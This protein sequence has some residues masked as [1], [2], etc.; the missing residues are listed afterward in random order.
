MPDR[1]QMKSVLAALVFLTAVIN[2]L[3]AEPARKFLPGQVISVTSRLTPIAQLAATNELHLAIS[4]PLRNERELDELLHQ[5]YDP[6]SLNF[7]KFL[8]SPEFAA[9]F[10]PTESDYAA[11]IGFVENR[12]LKVTHTHPNR[13]VLD[14]AGDVAHI[15]DSFQVTLNRYAHPN[16]PREFFSPTGEPSVP[17]G[18]NVSGISGLNNFSLP[19]PNSKI[20]PLSAAGKRVVPNA[21][22]GP[23]SGYMGGDFRAAYVP[24]VSL[25]GAS[26]SVAL[27]QFDGYVSNDIAA[28]ISWA[29]LGS[30]PISLTNVPVNGGVSVPGAGNGEVCLDIEM[31]LAMAPGV[32]KIIVYEAPNGSTSWSTILSQIANDNLARQVSC[33][34]GG[35]STDSGVN[36]IFKQMAAQG[37]SFFCASGD[38]D[39][40]TTS[41]PFLLDNTNIT[42][43]GGT[44]LTTASAG[45]AY[46]SETVWNDRTV[47]PNGGNWGSSGGVSPTYKIPS[48][49][50]SIDMTSNLGSTTMRNLPDVALTGDNCFIVADTNQLE[51]AGGTS[52]AAPLWAGFMALV[53]EQAA[54]AGRSPV[55]FLNPSIYAIGNGTNYASSLH[56]ITSGDNYWSSSPAKYPAV[57]GYDLCTGW[58]TPSGQP[59]MDALV[60]VAE[61]LGVL[62]DTGFTTVRGQIGGPFASAPQSVSLT[63]FSAVPLGWSVISTSAWLT[64]SASS[65]NLLA[66]GQTNL[67]VSVSAAANALPGGTYSAAVIFSNQTSGLAQSRLFMLKVFEPLQLL[68]TNGL[69][70]CGAAGGPFYPNT[71]LVTFTN[72]GSGAVAWSLINTSAWLSVSSV[73]G[74]FAG[75][76]LASVT[77][78]TNAVTAGL[79]NGTYNASLVL[80][81]QASHSAQSLFF[82]ALIGT[83]MV[84]NG[85]FETGDLTAWTLSGN[86]NSISSSISVRNTSTYIHSGSYGLRAQVSSPMGYLAQNLPTVPGQTYQLSFWFISSSASS[87][88]QFQATWNGTNVY[89]TS[90]PPT[91]WTN[92]KFIVTATSTN[93]QLQFGFLTGSTPRFGFDDISV[94]PVNLPVITQQPI[95]Q[96]N[97][98]G[99]NVSFIA[100]ATGSA[101]L[102][103]QWRTNGV[104]L[105]GANTNT[106]NLTAV[107]A[108]NSGNYA[109]VVTNAYGA[110]TS[111]VVT[112]AVVLPPA[113]TGS[114]LTNRTAEC[115]KNTN[116]YT[117]I[118]TGTAPLG[119][120][121]SLNGTPFAGAT[122]TSF[123]LTNLFVS[124]NLI[125]VIITNLY[126]SAG[127]NAVLM[128]QDTLTPVISWN[129]TNLMVAANSNC[130]ALLTN[131]TGTN[132]ILATDLSGSVTITQSPTNNATLQLGTNPVVLTVADA[133]GNKSYAT[134]TVVVQDQTPPQILSQPQSLTN[135]IGTT[136]T[137][138]FAAIA[139]TPLAFQWYSNNTAVAFFTNATLTLSNLV[140]SAAGNYF[141]VASANGG[142]TT[143][144]VVTLTVNL[145]PPAIHAVA[146]NSNNGFN[147]NLSGTPGYTY[148]L[149][150]TTNLLPPAN[151]LPLAT[152]TPGTN[153]VWSFTDPS[154]TN[155]PFQFYRL[156]LA[157]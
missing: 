28:Y 49:Q 53:N 116:T 56:D 24:G 33:S 106:L 127:S 44:V 122:N 107:T 34:W 57:A 26:Q 52:C 147:L 1:A 59:L 118:A 25:T 17:A 61:P 7:H 140:L 21:G 95:S 135:F 73:V 154:A 11:V 146:L 151:W 35:G 157:P 131:M 39:A 76:S 66:G 38:Y 105:T 109:L 14:V 156:K 121:W 148:I 64:V 46:V 99:S 111:S 80:S 139:C 91:S 20:S 60:G 36:A 96:T 72:Q 125:S 129:F 68:A 138:N 55:G 12:G 86:T 81:N 92:Q 144:G 143:S 71:A 40:Y 41:V 93:T 84:S 114:S 141:A 136:A 31:V 123:S 155:F 150:A 30:Y 137:F 82:S 134:N 113:I 89:S 98:A 104:N 79:A 90:S 37:Q 18:L 77:V 63:N 133:S 43:V 142:A 126:G 97:L 88:Q 42:L 152:G 6:R 27:L 2:G 8:T 51:I 108:N 87:G 119:I 128:V 120:Q 3:G 62:P 110:I 112:L 32:S 47:N 100:S 145:Y 15:E 69:T 101:P 103:F 124:T 45:G 74:S 10:G 13:L 75:N 65:G 78:F 67:T 5:L 115:G 94:T 29:G 132:F 54:T 4:L 23:G 153:G 22:S 83:N 50:Q 70:I 85:G 102:V 58:G 149:E 130:V 19:R 117:F 16:E 9:R 48:W